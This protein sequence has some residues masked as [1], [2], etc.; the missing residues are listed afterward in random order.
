MNFT[1][2]LWGAGDFSDFDT[3]SIRLIDSSTGT[4]TPYQFDQSASYNVSSNAVGN[5]TFVA[6]GSISSG[7]SKGYYLYF[8]SGTGKSAPGYSTTWG[9]VT[10]G[11]NIIEN[12]IIRSQWQQFSTFGP[13]M[14]DFLI[15]SSSR[16][17]CNNAVNTNS[18]IG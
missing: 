1:S 3:N 11:S 17:Q 5:L 14:S 10:A 9:S 2:L 16:D 6:T 15:K 18:R 12:D 4:E 13:G 7:T 8:D